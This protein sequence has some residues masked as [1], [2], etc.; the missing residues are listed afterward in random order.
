MRFGGHISGGVRGEV[1]AG[2]G[3]TIVFARNGINA[4]VDSSKFAASYING[5]LFN[6]RCGVALGIAFQQAGI[7]RNSAIRNI[8]GNGQPRGMLHNGNACTLSGRAVA[9]RCDSGRSAIASDG[10]TVYVQYTSTNFNTGLTADNTAAVDGGSCITG[11]IHTFTSRGDSG[12]I[13]VDNGGIFRIS[14]RA[15]HINASTQITRAIW[16]AI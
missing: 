3:D 9:I 6:V 2:D 13:E 11:Q 10:D 4:T 14:D 1:T 16:F 12:R 8:N 15:V 5:D 7:T